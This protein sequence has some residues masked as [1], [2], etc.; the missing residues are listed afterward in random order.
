M[1]SVSRSASY[2]FGTLAQLTLRAEPRDAQAAAQAVLAEFDRLHWKLHAWKGGELVALNRAIASGEERIPI[3]PELASLIRGATRLAERSRGLFDPAIGR[4]VGLWNFHAD[5]V[6]GAP[7]SAPQLG[8][9]LT[10]RPRM[11]DLAIE[12]ECLVCTN[13]AVQLDFGGYAKGYALD[14][15]RALLREHSIEG[16][17]VDL[18]GHVM[19]LGGRGERPWA[20]GLR[21]PRGAGL[22]ARLELRDGEV[23][24]TSGDYERFF[25]FRGKRYAHLIDPRTGA[26]ATSAQSASVLVP[27]AP[28][29]G[30]LSD[31]GSAALFLASCDDWRGAAARM[32]IGHVLRVEAT[33]KVELTEAMRERLELFR[34]AIHAAV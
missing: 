33:G 13:R 16:A 11:S 4:L 3:D 12:G 15:A 34:D 20:V 31:A 30:A 32:G 23:V 14:R 1:R 8:E 27:P 6:R 26:P 10:A 18:G 24:S 21:R 19:A 17:L 2:V 5:R 29:A 9:V 25:R 7:P 28:S 22:L